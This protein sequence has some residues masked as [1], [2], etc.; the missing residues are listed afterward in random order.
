M[1]IPTFHI[2]LTCI[3]LGKC[4]HVIRARI[5]NQDRHR[6]WDAPKHWKRRKQYLTEKSMYPN[7]YEKTVKTRWTEFLSINNC[8]DMPTET[9]N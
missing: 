1:C 5:R 3:F 6:K 9:Q 2:E 4:S 7:I 8:Y